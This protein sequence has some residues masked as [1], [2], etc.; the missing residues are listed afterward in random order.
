M[1]DD[2]GDRVARDGDASEVGRARVVEGAVH[3]ATGEEP[4]PTSY[5]G[6]AAPDQESKKKRGFWARLFG[7]GKDGKDEKD[8]PDKPEQNTVP[9]KKKG[10]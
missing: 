6:G 10:G 9:P 2:L 7:V 8:R 4:R 3:A 5:S 1:A